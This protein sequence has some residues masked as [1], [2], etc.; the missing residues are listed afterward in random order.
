MKTEIVKEEWFCTKC[1]Q[2]VSHEKKVNQKTI[3]FVVSGKKAKELAGVVGY[4][5]SRVSIAPVGGS[6]GQYSDWLLIILEVN[7]RTVATF[8][9]IAESL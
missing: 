7:K 6:K 5:D 8:T 4:G 1:R 9:F 2:M 3:S